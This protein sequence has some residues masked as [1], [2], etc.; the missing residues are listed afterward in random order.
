M[1]SPAVLAIRFETIMPLLESNH[2]E[3]M[4]LTWNDYVLS[5]LPLLA[6]DRSAAWG[7]SGHWRMSLDQQLVSLWRSMPHITH[8]LTRSVYANLVRSQ[9]ICY[10]YGH[11]TYNYHFLANVLCRI[12]IIQVVLHMYLCISVFTL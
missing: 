9:P 5:L 3:L 8:A 12:S 1:S 4:P 6:L 2:S 10:I 7:K 11:T